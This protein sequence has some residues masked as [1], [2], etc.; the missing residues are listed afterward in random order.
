M[1]R[2]D[3]IGHT[4]G[5]RY[6]V[7][8][9]LGQGGMSAVYKAFD[10]NLRRVV[11]VKIIHPHLSGDAQFVHR[12]EEEAAAV[13]KLRH[14]NLIQVYDFNNDGSTYYI[15]F[16][17]VPGE[18]IQARLKRLKAARRTMDVTV[19][20]KTTA[21]VA[22]GLQNAHK[23]GLI[24]RDIKPTNI[25]LNVSGEPI[26]MDFGIAKMLGGTQ[27]TATGAV[28][29]TARYM[30]PEQIQ[31]EL[32]DPRT[33]IYSLGVTLFEMLGGRPPFE[34]NSAMSLM[35]M[36][37][38]DPVP[39]L[40][41]LRAEVSP[42]L[43]AVV[44]KSLAKKPDDRY[45]TAAQM[46]AALRRIGRT[47]TPAIGATLIETAPAEI[48]STVIEPTGTAAAAAVTSV[49]STKPST[50]SVEASIP[51]SEPAAVRASADSGG[52]TGGSRG[53]FYLIGALIL[54]L[55]I[56][57]GVWAVFFRDTG[58]AE[59]ADA[60]DGVAAAVVEPTTT[61]DAAATQEA[62]D[63]AL[64]A[65]VETR[66]ALAATQTAEAFVP[67]PTNTAEPTPEATI[68][69]Q[70][71]RAMQEEVAPTMTMEPLI[72]SAAT[73]DGVEGQVMMITSGGEEVAVTQDTPIT[74][75]SQ[76]VTGP[77]GQITFELED[78]SIAQILADSHVSLDALGSAAGSELQQTAYTMFAGDILLRT[79]PGGSEQA[80][81]SDAGLLLATLN[82][83]S[84]TENL[85]KPLILSKRVR[86]SGRDA[87]MAVRMGDIRVFIACFSGVCTTAHG[88]SL[89]TG[90]EKVT[91]K[92]GAFISSF[93]ITTETSSYNLWQSNC[94]GCLPQAS[95]P[96]P[97]ATQ[98]ATATRTP[99]STV[100]PTATTTTTPTAADTT[101]T[102][103]AVDTTMT[104]TA[105]ATVD[106]EATPTPAAPTY[107]ARITGI[108]LENGR[109]YVNF[110]TIGYTATV[111][112]R[113][114]HFYFNTVP[115]S[116]AGV[117]GAGPWKLY[118]G[119]S[120]FTEYAQSDHVFEPTMMCIRVANEDHSIVYGS[121]N[122]Y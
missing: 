14:P 97:T 56:A 80:V 77:D 106:G 58:T 20:V 67:P 73:I 95:A 15:V 115:E 57:G 85:E 50:P 21:K 1:T 83:N 99:Q 64:A 82:N 69:P 62:V 103:T 89:A 52:K 54:L 36:H 17:Y 79:P 37:V 94:T 28:L 8:E 104:P 22:D 7:Q 4:I 105:E 65:E 2:P 48:D 6:Q 24:H 71:T 5:G 43:V 68:E 70:E 81:Y 114:V 78:G 42:E 12:F 23:K 91:G 118:G 88:N 102:P 121:G 55:L 26:V 47:T 11:A 107:A 76:F 53:A 116:D 30:S 16:E 41:A 90:W 61:A 84:I 108:T 44:N 112:G 13:A 18:T 72:D 60:D 46:A 110:E 34:A 59:T 92:D 119:P 111:P 74:F 96:L 19:A 3:W 40:S 29:G 100:T 101:M 25:I 122:C 49:P 120:P 45:Q 10:P 38:T 51:K 63:A 66:L 33:D 87:A 27:H 35:M 109:Y 75:G 9:L 31:G 32:V 113:H 39:D 98:T 93:P 117:P 86:Q